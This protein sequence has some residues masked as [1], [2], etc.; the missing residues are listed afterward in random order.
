MI[1]ELSLRTLEQAIR[2]ALALDEKS[3]TRLAAL[4]GKTLALVIL[5]LDVR[6]FIEF[7]H[8]S[9]F[10]KAHTDHI[11]DCT[12][13]SSPMGLVRLSLLP[14]SKA[15]S[16][17]N[18]HIK[19]EG[20]AEFGEAVKALFDDLDIDWEG[21]LAYFTGD[22]VAHQ[23]GNVVRKGA[24]FTEHLRNSFKHQFGDFLKEELRVSPGQE[25]LRDFFDDVDIIRADVE[26]LAAKIALL[27]DTP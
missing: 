5:P 24:A 21:H 13:K 26:R 10:I 15:R 9:L 25:E 16:L 2:S 18:D 1:K 14:A 3:S 27:K 7:A 4:D 12:I 23:I 11:P 6:F 22:V 17:F 20:N 8:S 19:M